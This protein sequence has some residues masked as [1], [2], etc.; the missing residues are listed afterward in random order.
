[1]RIGLEQLPMM[2]MLRFVFLC[3]CFSV[4]RFACAAAVELRETGQQHCYS[5]SGIELA[6]CAG[7]LQDGDLLAGATWPTP[8]FIRGSGPESACMIDRLTG[9]MWIR[10]PM[11]SSMY[12]Q[13]AI[14]IVLTLDMCGHT[15][16]RVP[17][18]NEMFSLVNFDVPD[19]TQ[20]LIRQ[21]FDSNILGQVCHWTS[22]TVGDSTSF[23]MSVSL[24][25]PNSY[26]RDKDDYNCYFLPVRTIN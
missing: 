23:A 6:S 14:D 3:L 5:P 17:N 22:T 13:S 16:W 8:R 25:D 10:K 2:P 9:L 4:S 7:T 15:D 11:I 26:A 1:M 20:W 19:S 18:L 24:T 12:W 21:G